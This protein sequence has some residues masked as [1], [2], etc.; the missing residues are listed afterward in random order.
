MST[1]TLKD[2]TRCDLLVI[3]AGVSGLT[4]AIVAAKQGLKVIVVEKAPVFGGTAAFSG[5]VLW[6][7]GNHVAR[8]AGIRDTR[9]EALAY[10]R[11]ETGENFDPEAIDAFLDAA[12]EMAEFFERETEVKF[13]ATQYPD[14]HPDQ[15]GA[16]Q[17]GRSILAKPYDIRALGDDM[18]RLRP[19]L[20]TITF[21]GMMF[22]S[23]SPDIKHFFNATKSLTSFVYVAKR[24]AKHLKELAVYHRGVNVTSGNALMARLAKTTLDLGIP[25]HTGCPVSRLMETSQRITGAVVRTQAAKSACSRTGRWCWP[26]A[27]SRTMR[28]GSSRST[29]TSIAAAATCRPRR[30]KTPATA[31]GSPNSAA[32][33]C[34][35]T[36]RTPRPGSPCPTFRSAR[37]DT[38]SSLTSSTATSRASSASSRPAGASPTSP[39]RTTTWGRP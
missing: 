26:P 9:E 4:T 12:P 5:G 25:I 38:G 3:G 36:T 37:V 33:P 21:I 16:A 34:A 11:N 29:R 22:N 32:P 13:V 19:P 31:F 6:I 24:L 7:P 17:V 20:K 18:K 30:P 35:W 15:I 14:Y 28:R 1:P 8:S 39:T 2:G 27:A 10:I 23:S